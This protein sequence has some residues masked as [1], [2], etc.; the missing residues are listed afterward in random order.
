MP[1]T[2]VQR[3]FNRFRDPAIDEATREL[4]RFNRRKWK[5]QPATDNV[6]LVGLFSWRPSMCAY[7]IV[8][9]HFAKRTVARIEAYFFGRQVDPVVKEIYRSF[10]AP[11]TLGWSSTVRYEAEAKQLA[12]EALATVQTADD[13][14][15]IGFRDVVLGDLIYDS[16]L[17]YF[18][19]PTIRLDDPRF[20]ETVEKA[21]A[22]NVVSRLH[23]GVCF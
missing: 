5:P 7:S 17:R 6:V 2:L 3:L 13:V 1:A 10:G 20:R 16:Y 4:I 19:E 12:D 15:R 22:E 11:L 21:D 18:Y 8:A 9:N 23:G 14:F